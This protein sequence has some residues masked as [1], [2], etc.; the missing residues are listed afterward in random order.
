MNRTSVQWMTLEKGVAA[1][2]NYQNFGCSAAAG[3]L[4]LGSFYRAGGG[5][6]SSPSSTPT[7]E[8]FP[9]AAAQCFKETFR[10]SPPATTVKGER[11][12]EVRQKRGEREREMDSE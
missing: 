3:R 6:S 7:P 9:S 12:R 10:L 2:R 4:R 1:R 8:T 5:G 11:E